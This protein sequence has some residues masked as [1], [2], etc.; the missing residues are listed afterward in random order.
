M[1]A[2]NVDRK[3]IASFRN[4]AHEVDPSLKSEEALRLLGIAKHIEKAY[5]EGASITAPV[6]FYG[7]TYVRPSTDF[8]WKK[9]VLMLIDEMAGSCGDITPMLMKNNGL[10]TLFGKRTMGLGGNVESVT[11]NHSRAEVR[12]TRGLFA[13]YKP[14]GDYAATDF[15]ENNGVEPDV[16]YEHSVA[17]FRAGYVAYM[18]AFSDAAVALAKTARGHR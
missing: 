11:L 5:D 7:D 18:D 8:V 6:A 2:F 4:D 9:P 13:T 10:A 12:F 17:D 14:A 3:W 16:P 1:Q 15:V